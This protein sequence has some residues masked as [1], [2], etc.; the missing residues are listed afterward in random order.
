MRTTGH[1]SPGTHTLGVDVEESGLVRGWAGGARVGVQASRVKPRCGPALSPFLAA[2]RLCHVPGVLNPDPEGPEDSV[3]RDHLG[4][5]LPAAR[6][7]TREE[8]HGL[9]EPPLPEEQPLP[10]CVCCAKMYP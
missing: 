8:V 10:A 1:G 7:K 5:A 9:P 2:P 6:E 3:Q 4:C